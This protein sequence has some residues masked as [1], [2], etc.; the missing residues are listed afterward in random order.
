MQE[1]WGPKISGKGPL[2]A[3]PGLALA[4]QGRCLALALAHEIGS[5]WPDLTCPA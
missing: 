3:S 2:P 1:F 5:R 4:L